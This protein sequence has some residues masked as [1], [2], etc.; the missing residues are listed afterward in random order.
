MVI[1]LTTILYKPIEDGRRTLEYLIEYLINTADLKLILRVDKSIAPTQSIIDVYSYHPDC[2]GQVGGSF[3]L[4]SG[5]V[6]T[7]TCKQNIAT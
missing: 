1:V 6:F 4:G 2:K 3:T 5:S 7:V